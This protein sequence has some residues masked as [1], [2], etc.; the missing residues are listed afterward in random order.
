MKEREME[1]VTVKDNMENKGVEGIDMDKK[2]KKRASNKKLIIIIVIVV[3]VQVIGGIALSKVMGNMSKGMQEAMGQ[4]GGAGETL[5]EVKKVDVKQEITTSATVIGLEKDAYTSPVTAK[6]ENVCVEPGQRVKAGDVLLTFDAS[7]LGDNLAKVQLQAKTERATGEETYETAREA[8]RKV[9]VAKK[10]IKALKKDVKSIQKDIDS[11]SDKVSKYEAK[12][13]AANAAAMAG[14]A[15]AATG[16]S[17]SETKA[18]QKVTKDLE[19][20]NKKLMKKEEAI[21]KQEAIVEA[22]KDIKVSKSAAAQIRNTNEMSAM[23]VDDAKKDVD[24]AK[25]GITAKAD[26]IVESVE[27]FKGAY[28]NETQTLMTLINAQKI[29]VEFSISKDDLAAITEGQKARVV[30]GSNEYTGSVQYVSRVATMDGNALGNEAA[31]SGSIKGRI[32][33]DAPDENI[34]VGVSAKAYIFIGEAKGA[35]AIPY[36]ALCTDVDGD[37]VYTVNDKNIIERK[38]VK[39]GLCSGE[40]YEVLEG[41]KEGDKVITEVEKNMKPGD[42][43][44][45]PVAAG[46]MS[47][48]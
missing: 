19:A 46:G 9:T 40:Y 39:L 8:A 12:T 22:N 32:V 14:D 1:D 16:L 18:Y 10:E 15:S 26:G 37:Y 48:Q 5:H 41:I 28:A 3:A 36:S 29:G 4:M 43:Y 17:E 44:V 6:V 23:N 30:I 13:Q 33:L 21:A 47:I 34:F 27:I 35:L 25:A 42:E 45:P 2:K 24:A 11:L 20:K 38:D 31:A 7:E